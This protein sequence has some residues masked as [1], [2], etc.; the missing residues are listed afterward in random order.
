MQ[1]E[2]VK[3]ELVEEFVA[4]VRFA[5]PPVNAHS[6]QLLTET[7]YVFDTISDRDDIRAVILTGEG[8]T[9]C[10]GADIKERVG[11]T[12]QPGD[13][14]QRSRRAREA[15]HSIRECTKP[16][17]AA[18][19]GP[20][21]GGGLAFVA[22]CDIL[23]AADTGC[24][25]LPEIDVGLL[26][27]GRHA[28]RLF[29]HSRLRRMMLTGMRVFGPELYRLGI[30]EASVPVE[31]LMDT[32][33]EIARNIAGKS[34]L[35]TRLAKHALNQI[36]EMSLRDGY[37]FEQTMTGQLSQSEDSKEAMRAFVEKRKPVFKGR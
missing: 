36:E 27:G 22:S 20:A 34:P 26:G 24:V 14:W 29:G 37:R 30:V 18:I 5:N 33:L 3:L 2:V 13:H 4:V 28:Q 15:Y 12:P 35:A 7:A 17:I 10:A 1:P 6:Q 23:V 21:L 16:V 9:F 25:G 8:K 31:Q 11:T 19:N 32:A